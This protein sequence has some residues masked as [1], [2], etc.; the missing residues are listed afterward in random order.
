MPITPRRSV[1]HLVCTLLCLH[2][3]PMPRDLPFAPSCAPQLAT[4]FTTYGPAPSKQT[5]RQSQHQGWSGLIR[6]PSNQRRRRRLPACT[7]N[8]STTRSMPAS[9]PDHDPKC[10][11]IINSGFHARHFD[12]VSGEGNWILLFLLAGPPLL[13]L[14]SFYACLSPSDPVSSPS[15]PL[16]TFSVVLFSSRPLGRP[17]VDQQK[18]A[19]RQWRSRRRTCCSR[20]RS[21]TNWLLVIPRA[22]TCDQCLGLWHH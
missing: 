4:G 11:Q 12:D 5:P 7:T 6:P 18:C 2:I 14:A 16:P 17:V 15:C 21:L 10:R 1:P 8:S 19:L 9:M 22:A 13:L 3:G 20:M